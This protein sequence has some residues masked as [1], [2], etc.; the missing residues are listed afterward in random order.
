MDLLVVFAEGLVIRTELPDFAGQGRAALEV[1]AAD[2]I[3]GEGDAGVEHIFAAAHAA[4]Q[5]E[6]DPLVRLEEGADCSSVGA[7]VVAES[8]SK[9]ELVIG[10]VFQRMEG[11]QGGRT[12]ADAVHPAA[13]AA[14][15]IAHVFHGPAQ[16]AYID[17]L[18]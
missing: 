7:A 3:Q 9:V 5:V 6:A 17:G 10:I 18:H 15:G 14:D 13:Q 2:R 16:L 4:A 11:C 12:G 1:R 8:G